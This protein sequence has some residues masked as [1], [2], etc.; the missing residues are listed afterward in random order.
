MGADEINRRRDVFFEDVARAFDAGLE[1]AA[2]EAAHGKD[3]VEVARQALFT[4]LFKV[5]VTLDRGTQLA[6]DSRVLLVDEDGNEVTPGT[7]HADFTG[8][9]WDTGRLG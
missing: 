3:A 9:L 8:H 6:D 4:C 5:F 7:L 2:E 1:V